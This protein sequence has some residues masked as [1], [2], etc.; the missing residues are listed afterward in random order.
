[1]FSALTSVLSLQFPPTE[2]YVFAYQSAPVFWILFLA[3]FILLNKQQ[4]ANLLVNESLG[5][6]VLEAEYRTAISY[7]NAKIKIKV[8]TKISD[9]EKWQ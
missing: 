7:T 3:R 1:M 6:G 4:I 5:L 9:P 2:S 8:K